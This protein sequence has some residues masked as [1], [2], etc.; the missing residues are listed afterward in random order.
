M[1]IPLRGR[2]PRLLVALLLT[3]P[4]LW[5]GGPKNDEGE[6]Q[7]AAKRAEEL[8]RRGRFNEAIKEQ[9]DALRLA[10]KLYGAN[11]PR[12]PDQLDNLARLHQAAGQHARAES[13]LQRSLKIKQ[14]K[15]GKD[16]AAVARALYNLAALCGHTGQYAKAEPLYRR[17]LGKPR[18]PGENQGCLER[19]ALPS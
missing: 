18:V 8:R 16:H 9:Q 19:M 12:T 15:L 6:L 7:A 14:A 3:V 11:D 1:S 10:E 13:L 2:F 5:A 17:S 4:P